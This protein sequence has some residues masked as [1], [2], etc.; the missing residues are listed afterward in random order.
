MIV[1]GKAP[2]VMTAEAMLDALIVTRLL[3]AACMLALYF[4]S[5]LVDAWLFR[6]A[7][8]RISAVEILIV[9]GTLA[10]ATEIVRPARAFVCI[11]LLCARCA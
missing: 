6:V 11:C 2:G 3:G 9:V 4:S 1:P 5:K 7:G 10:Q 8:V